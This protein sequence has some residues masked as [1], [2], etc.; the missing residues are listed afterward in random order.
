[1]NQTKERYAFIHLS[2]VDMSRAISSIELLS[3]QDNEHIRDALMRDAV[4][5]YAKPFSSNKGVISK[6]RLRIDDSYIPTESLSEHKAVIAARNK[7][8]AHVDLDGQNPQVEVYVI[9]GKRG[10]DLMVSGYE[11]PNILGLASS[12]RQLAGLVQN[13]LLTERS[14]LIRKL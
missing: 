3:L 4:I 7:L 13:L 8:I 10:A 9:A 1:M 6:H 2:I 12:V 14:E 5:S 11:R